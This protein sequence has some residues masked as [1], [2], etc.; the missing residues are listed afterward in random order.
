MGD[1]QRRPERSSQIY[2]TMLVGF[3]ALL[4][5]TRWILL[6]LPGVLLHEMSHL[7]TAWLLRVRVRR[8]R[9]GPRRKGQG[10]QFTL[11]SVDIARTD[12]IRA[13]LIGLAPLVAGCAAILL[14]SERV[15]HI[16]TLPVLGNQESW[17]HLNAIYRTPDFWLWTYLILSIG[18]AMLPSA[19]DRQSWGI[20]LGFVAFVGAVLYFTGLLEAVSVPLSRWGTNS[21][22]QLAY[23]FAVMVVV[24]GAFVVVLFV[25]EQALGLVGLGRVQYQ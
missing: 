24:D 5:L 7:L 1:W 4:L 15:F 12:P 13:S 16:E 23:A 18:N 22:N 21:V 20:A 8:F 10:Q 17:G 19:A 14:I 2:I 11:G 9:I 6:V 3:L 25:I